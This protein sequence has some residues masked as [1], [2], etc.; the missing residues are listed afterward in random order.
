MESRRNT[1]ARYYRPSGS[2]KANGSP[3]PEFTTDEGRNYL[4]VTIFAHQGFR[5]KEAVNEAVNEVVN[6]VEYISKND[7]ENRLLNESP[8]HYHATS[9]QARIIAEI[10]EAPDITIRRLAELTGV[11]KSTLEREIKAMKK[12]GRIRRVG[13]DKT[14]RWDVIVP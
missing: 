8:A 9:R 11:S 10:R 7:S 5:I 6:E 13:S 1:G 2:L 3:E 12:A 14:G 4:I